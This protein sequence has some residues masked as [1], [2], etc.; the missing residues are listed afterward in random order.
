M[1]LIVGNPP[2][3]HKQNPRCLYQQQQTGMLRKKVACYF[4]STRLFIESTSTIFLQLF[5]VFFPLTFPQPICFN[6]H[7]N[8]TL[9][10]LIPILQ[11]ITSFFVFF[12]GIS[13]SA[14]G[15][16][17][18]WRKH[19]TN[20]Y[21]TGLAPWTTC[22][23]GICVAKTILK[24][25]CL[26]GQRMSENPL[27]KGIGRKLFRKLWKLSLYRNWV[28][29]PHPAWARSNKPNYFVGIKQGAKK[30]DRFERL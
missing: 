11:K 6:K 5:V 25:Q 28:V 9:K 21:L 2:L 15:F 10:Q 24:G 30:N 23:H 29:S 12:R 7:P 13:E 16:G 4:H 20:T 19:P 22:H 1:I 27:Q 17:S 26:E 14:K 8:M 18:G 3:P